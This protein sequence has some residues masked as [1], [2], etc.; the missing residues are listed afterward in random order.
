MHIVDGKEGRD[1]VS[2]IEACNKQKLNT[3][4]RRCKH[5]CA[6]T[7]I[8]VVGYTRGPRSLNTEERVAELERIG[9]LADSE[10]EAHA[11]QINRLSHAPDSGILHTERHCFMT[12]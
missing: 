5:K 4:L 3:G 12:E 2:W 11:Q 10:R 8:T 1:A 7:T 6:A 9:W